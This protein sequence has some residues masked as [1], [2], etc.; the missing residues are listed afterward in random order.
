MLHNYAAVYTTV[1]YTTL[2]YTTLTYLQLTYAAIRAKSTP[3]PTAPASTQMTTCHD[4]KSRPPTVRLSPADACL[5]CGSDITDCSRSYL[6]GN[7]QLGNLNAV[8]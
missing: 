6:T 2:H 1:Y 7:A 5:L 8:L 4:S 3:H